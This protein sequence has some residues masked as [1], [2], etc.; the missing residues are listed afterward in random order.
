M[1]FDS[2]SAVKLWSYERRTGLETTLLGNLSSENVFIINSAGEATSFKVDYTITRDGEIRQG[3][4]TA[5]N[6]GSTGTSF[7]DEY[8]ETSDAGVTLSVDASGAN[9][10]LNY[11]SVGVS[12]ATFKYSIVRLD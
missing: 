12:D 2:T 9:S 1:A 4:I 8:N 3:S 10:E 5:T 6:D 7:N 11:T